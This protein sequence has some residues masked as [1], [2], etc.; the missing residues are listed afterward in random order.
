MDGKRLLLVGDNPFHGISHLSQ[1]RAASRGADVGSPERGAGLV[2]AALDHGADGFMFSASETTL[3]ILRRLVRDRKP[4]GLRLYVIVPYAYEY[5]RMAVRAG[6]VPGLARGVGRQILASGNWRAVASG[7]RGALFGDPAAL[8][9]SYLS[10]ETSRVRSAAGGKCVLA[11]VMLH[12]LLTDMA[13]ALDMKWV[14]EAHI[15]YMSGRG[16]KP[17]FETRNLPYLV[18]RFREWGI[19]PRGVALA[20]SFNP[21]GF[22]MCPSKEAC[23]EALRQVPGAEVIAFSILAAGYVKPAEAAAYVAALPSLSGVAVGVSRA[24]QAR[25][26]FSLLRGEL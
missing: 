7:A 26:T 22:Q 19:D 6:G 20:A 4:E 2:A 11:S 23:E 15:E 25:E 21:A 1:A 16:V 9:R 5:V 3:G 24:E 10:L 13:L 18:R 14:A 12:E 8:L 17:G